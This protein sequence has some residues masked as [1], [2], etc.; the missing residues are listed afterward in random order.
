MFYST[1][2]SKG[3]TD[4]ATLDANTKIVW[5][6]TK[7]PLTSKL[8]DFCTLMH[9]SRTRDCSSSSSSSNSSGDTSSSDADV[10]TDDCSY[11]YVITT[12]RTEHPGAPRLQNSVRS[13]I[14]LGV[15]TITPHGNG[16]SSRVTTVNHI[17]SAGVPAVIAD[18]VS[19]RNAV[20]FIVNVSQAAGGGISSSN[21]TAATTATASDADTIKAASDSDCDS[22]GA[23][24]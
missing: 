23:A 7:P 8:H 14:V 21:A 16:S 13:E 3:R 18:R 6:K 11:S 12:T 5:N 17:V 24:P 22:E 15:T 19:T 2:D 20:D 4:I 1:P 9:V 10:S